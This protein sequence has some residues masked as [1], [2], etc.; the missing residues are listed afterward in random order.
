M[1]PTVLNR[2]WRPS[3]TLR[4]ARQHRADASAKPPSANTLTTLLQRAQQWIAARER[5]VASW[6]AHFPLRVAPK[7][8]ERKQGAAGAIVLPHW[9]EYESPLKRRL[10]LEALLRRLFAVVVAQRSAA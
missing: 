6:L 3:A 8:P 7:T 10:A 9:W 5:L 2:T 1:V 4:A